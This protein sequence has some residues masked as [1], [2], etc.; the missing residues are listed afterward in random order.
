MHASVSSAERLFGGTGSVV[1]CFWPCFIIGAFNACT[2]SAGFYMFYTE[3]AFGLVI[4]IS[5]VLQT[6]IDGASDASR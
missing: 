1:A 3:L 4:V 5:V 2:V 6:L